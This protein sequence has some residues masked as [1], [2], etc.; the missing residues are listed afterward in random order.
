[1]GIQVGR[2]PKNTPVKIGDGHFSR[3]GKQL[4]PTLDGEEIKQQN[5]KGGKREEDWVGVRLEEA[6]QGPKKGKKGGACS[7]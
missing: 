4:T 6:V 1:L 2:A 3:K 7:S 5:G